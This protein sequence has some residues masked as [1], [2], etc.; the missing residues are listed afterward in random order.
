VPF[1]PGDSIFE[2]YRVAAER[3]IEFFLIDLD[4]AEGSE[5]VSL[6]PIPEPEFA[7]RLGATFARTFEV[8]NEL[9]PV[10]PKN[11]AREAFMARRLSEL[12]ASHERVLWVGGFAHWRRIVDRIG[13]KD[14]S[15]PS[16][17]VVSARIFERVRLAPSAL[18]A[19]T[20]RVPYLVARY[21]RNPDRYDESA[22]IRTLALTARRVRR[23]RTP[24]LESAEAKAPVDIARMLV[25]ARN[26][27]AT[28][29]IGDRPSLG[30][31][32]TAGSA[33]VSNRYAGRLYLTAMEEHTSGAAR[34]YGALTYEATGKEHGCRYRGCWISVRPYW[35]GRG[36]VIQWIPSADEA[37]RRLRNAPCR[38]LPAGR[39]D[40][41]RGWASYPDEEERYEAFV[42]Y[43]LAKAS[44][45]DPDEPTIVPFAT[46]L[47]DG[48]DVRATLRHW[49]DGT[50][51]VRDGGRTPLKITNGLID[52]SSRS[53][54]SAVLR[55]HGQDGHE[56]G[57]SD[58]S[59]VHVGS[60]S[61]Q[62]RYCTVL[63]EQ[64][65]QVTLHDRELSLITTDVP[66]SAPK[67]SKIP[68]FYDRVITELIELGP[69]R[70]NLYAWLDVMFRFCSGKPFV[71]YS[72]YVP[73][74]RIHAIARQYRVRVVH[75]PLQQ[76]PR[77]LREQNRRFHLLYLTRPQW[78]ALLAQIA[79][80]KRAWAPNGNTNA[81]SIRGHA[82]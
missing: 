41:K 4:C 77:I 39:K 57:W 69:D 66:T 35:P 31:L 46:G 61:R 70:D 72:R 6:V 48:I 42:R 54:D 29:Q 27:A 24:E 62:A 74:P 47:R 5:C 3:A 36:W 14:F 80:S 43:V 38:L 10:S 51:Y 1:V 28:R 50:I 60:A 59:L 34:R 55:G 21:A 45:S 32:L 25:Y 20:G 22:G 23:E 65:C 30:D 12:M 26:L 81:E 58:P 11:S 8:L 13:G 15:A 7:P 37:E 56:A 2:A 9:N 18:L 76:I 67:G 68:S 63:Q 40:E 52:F 44:L 53:E 17:E 19:M 71:Y 16:V 33:I 75:R 82:T 64:P 79:E 73:G 49:K 78:E